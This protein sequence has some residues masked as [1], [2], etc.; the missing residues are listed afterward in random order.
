MPTLPPAVQYSFSRWP[1]GSQMTW[2]CARTCSL[3][4]HHP[5]T[6]L[7][8]SLTTPKK[9]YPTFLFLLIRILIT[10]GNLISLSLSQPKRSLTITFSPCSAAH[11]IPQTGPEFEAYARSQQALYHCYPVIADYLDAR[12]AAWSSDPAAFI[13]SSPGPQT[14][15]A[16]QSSER[17]LR[18]NGPEVDAKIRNQSCVF[19]ASIFG[20]LTSQ[21]NRQTCLIGL[22]SPF[23]FWSPQHRSWP[24]DRTTTSL[25]T[26]Y[27]RIWRSGRTG[28]YSYAS[29]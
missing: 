10:S 13:D 7:H 15:F 1:H 22:S 29:P 18:C 2:R 24:Q 27:A 23:R 26:R 25:D 6:A 28:S 12:Q 17:I 3:F 16:I 4:W 11:Q 14:Q 21:N 9:M 5:T 19:C 8:P 20:S